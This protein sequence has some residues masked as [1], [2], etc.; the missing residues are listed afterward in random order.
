VPLVRRRRRRNKGSPPAMPGEVDVSV[1]CTNCVFEIPEVSERPTRDRK[2]PGEVAPVPVDADVDRDR[3]E[4]A[5]GTSPGE[6]L[7]R[8]LL[9]RHA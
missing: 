9:W 8:K 6:G 1:A 2:I 7:R 4:S 5:A 3:L